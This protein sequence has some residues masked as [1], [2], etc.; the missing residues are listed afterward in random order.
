MRKTVKIIS[1]YYKGLILLNE[2]V[3]VVK[4]WQFFKPGMSVEKV[5]VLIYNKPS[6]NQLYK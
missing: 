1:K 3:L 4:N 6:T 5:P 2:L